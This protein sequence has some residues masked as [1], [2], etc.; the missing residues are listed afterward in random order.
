MRFAR[1]FDA[2]RAHRFNASQLSLPQPDT[3]VDLATPFR[4]ISYIVN[5]MCEPISANRLISCLS[6][7]SSKVGAHLGMNLRSQTGALR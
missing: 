2:P 5:H 3:D 7:H 4:R 6:G 1:S